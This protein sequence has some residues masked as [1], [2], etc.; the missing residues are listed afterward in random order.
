MQMCTTMYHNKNNKAIKKSRCIE[1]TKSFIEKK[2]SF[3]ETGNCG[4][5][6]VG[7]GL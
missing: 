4:S 7:F 2:H 1:Q 6:C 5:L 3:A